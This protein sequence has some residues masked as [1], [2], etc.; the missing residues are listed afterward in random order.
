MNDDH[1]GCSNLSS[2][3]DACCLPAGTYYLVVDGY[4]HS[5]KGN[6]SLDVTFGCA[7]CG[8]DEDEEEEEACEELDLIDVD[9]PYHG[10]VSNDDAPDV[11]GTAAGD[12]AFRFSVD[13]NTA[14]TLRTCYAGTTIDADSYWYRGAS[15]CDGGELLRYNDGPQGCNW[16]TLVNYGCDSLLAAGTY[17]VIVSGW[18]CQEGGIELDLST[19]T[20]AAVEALDQPTGMALGQNSP[21]PFNPVTSIAFTMPETDLARLSVFDLGGREVAVLVDGLTSAGPHR[22]SFD[23]SRLSSGVYLY[24]LRT[25][26]LI[27]TRKMI[28][29]K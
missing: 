22:V 13:G 19:S 17:V 2:L 15:P 21:N 3:I 5:A 4:G 24:T 18:E 1:T 11:C 6:F 25:S 28:L 8:G 7:P 9:L 20:C 29:T 10:I 26:R 12:V 16:A 14:V 23:G 27:E